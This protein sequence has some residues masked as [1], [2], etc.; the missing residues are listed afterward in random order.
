MKSA[1]PLRK[2]RSSLYQQVADQIRTMILSH[3]LQPGDKID[4]SAICQQ[5]DVSRTP[6]REALKVLNTEGLI[7][8]SNHRGARVAVTRPD[9]VRQLFPIIGALEALAG[10]LAC[11]HVSEGDI[12][13]LQSL[14]DEMLICYQQKDYAGYAE[15]NREIHLGLFQLADNPA[16]MA[17]YH[18]LDIRTHAVR[19]VARKSQA[20]WDAAIADHQAMLIA[21]RQRNGEALGQILRRHLQSKAQMVL[22]FLDDVGP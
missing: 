17:L 20:E 12:S 15:H 22:G 4:E 19:H 1:V 21:L 16:L 3:Q 13:Y 5:F 9:D 8:L 14:H 2:A 7:A 18:Q 6:V 10:E 11:R